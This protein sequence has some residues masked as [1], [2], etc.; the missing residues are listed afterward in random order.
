[1]CDYASVGGAQMH[2][3][4]VVCVYVC[5]CVCMCVCV[6]FSRKLMELVDFGLVVLLWSY[7]VIYIRLLTLT[8]VFAVRSLSK[9]KLPTKDCFSTW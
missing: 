6:C 2:M 9:S 8:A 1:M 4:V 5:V 7:G 3:V